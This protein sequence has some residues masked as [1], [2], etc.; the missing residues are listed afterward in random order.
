MVENRIKEQE[1]KIVTFG[2]LNYSFQKMANV[3]GWELEEIELLMR[4]DE[5]EFCKLYQQGADRAD[6]LID[7]KLFEMALAGD[8]KALQKY[9]M[10]RRKS[11]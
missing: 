8:L 4:D 5:S 2:A 9:E 6:Y 1:D 11:K 10:R 7:K 3:L